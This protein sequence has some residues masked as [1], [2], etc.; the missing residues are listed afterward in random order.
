MGVAE[1]HSKGSS[2]HG[3]L[4]LLAEKTVYSPG[5]TVVGQI[6]FEIK[7]N[8]EVNGLLL[9]FQGEERVGI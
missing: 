5:D 3:S 2:D 6:A 4:Y 1:S 7:K 9:N 8:F